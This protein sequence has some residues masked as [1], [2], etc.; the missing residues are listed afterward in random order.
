MIRVA[1][2]K[3]RLGDKAYYAFDKLGYTVE[4]FGTDRRLVL[5]TGCKTLQYFLVKPSDVTTYVERGI[6]DIGIAGKDIV[7]ENKAD[8]YELVDL[9]FGT[10]Y[11]AICGYPE[12]NIYGKSVLRIATKF[13]NITKAYFT[14]KNI[15]TEVIY[16]NGSIELAPILGMSDVIVDI[17]ETGATLSE[18]N[19]VVLEKIMPISARLIAN[20]SSYKFNHAHIVQLVEQLK[21]VI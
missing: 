8:I 5:T 17:V 19:L 12:T 10:C 6:A 18:N 15:P 9:G 20:K 14:T 13:T 4:N 1:L 2:P 11:M 7:D 21:A 3:G 16:L